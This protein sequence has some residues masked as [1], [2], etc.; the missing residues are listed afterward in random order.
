MGLRSHF[1]L[2]LLFLVVDVP[3]EFVEQVFN[4]LLLFR[5]TVVGIL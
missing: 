2:L 1:F 5:L 4:V 3:R